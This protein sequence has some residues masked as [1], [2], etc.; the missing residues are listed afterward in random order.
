M[1]QKIN[2]EE[3]QIKIKNF[4]KNYFKVAQIKIESISK[5]D[6][7][8]AQIKIEV[9]EISIKNAPN[10]DSSVALKTYKK[11]DWKYDLKMT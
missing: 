2:F 9:A 1:S 6:L 11:N 7:K 10:E 8:V 5:I 4:S 3:A